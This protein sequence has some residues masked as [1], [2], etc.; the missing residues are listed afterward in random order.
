MNTLESYNIEDDLNMGFEP[1][2]EPDVETDVETDVEQDG[3]DQMHPSHRVAHITFISSVGVVFAALVVLFLFFPR[4]TFSEL[5]NRDLAT[6]PHPKGLVE[7]PSKYTGDLSAWFS[8]TEPYRDKF[9][10]MSRSIRESFK[11]RF[12]DDQE[13]VTIKKTTETDVKDE[14]LFET[15]EA[16]GNPLEEA[17]AKVAKA[18]ILVVGEGPNVRAFSPFKGKPESVKPYIK[19]MDDFREA[20]PNVNLYAMVIPGAAAFYVPKKAADASKPMQPTFDYLKANLDPSVKYVDVYSQLAGHTKENIY[21]RTDHHWAPRG[22][23][24]AARAL[25]AAAGVPFKD[26]SNY[27]EHVVHGYVGSMYM[28]SKDNS[29]KNAPEDFYYYTPKGTNEKTTYIAYNTDKA[30]GKMTEKGPY[31]GNFFIHFKDGSGGAYCTFM[32]GDHYL[33][34]VETGVPNNRRLLIVKDSHGNPLPSYLFYSFQ[35]IHV[36]DYRYFNKNLKQYVA[37]NKITDI[38]L[39]FG[40]NTSCTPGSMQ[41]VRNFLT[42]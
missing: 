36:V 19:L 17:D 28:Y 14:E 1:D 12:G 35:E 30:T 10:N 25:A 11:F 6:F 7:D 20:F 32:G 2:I 38:A 13:K 18:G 24:Y 8:D 21:L 34:K 23:Y 15:P 41:K 37:D 29:V 40:I 26:L 16:Q 9:M 3:E 27:D 22:A 39:A 31:E 33:V 42:Q 5:E 4:S